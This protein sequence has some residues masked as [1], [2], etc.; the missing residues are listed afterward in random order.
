MFVRQAYLDEGDVCVFELIDMDDF[1]VKGSIS[2]HACKD[3]I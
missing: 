3:L 1:M 2:N